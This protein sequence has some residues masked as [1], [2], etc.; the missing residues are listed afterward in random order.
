V[1]VPPN[2][3]DVTAPWIS[4]K[5]KGSNGNSG[6]YSCGI[7]SAGVWLGWRRYLLALASPA[8]SASRPGLSTR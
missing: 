6:I 5:T 4:D 8:A 7:R 2:L 3:Y 1:F